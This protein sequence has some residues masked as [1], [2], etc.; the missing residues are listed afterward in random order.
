MKSLAVGGHEIW[1][2]DRGT[3]LPLVLLHGF[4][5]DHT[6][7]TEQID[8]LAGPVRVLAAR[9]ARLRPQPPRDNHGQ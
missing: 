2:V 5:L 3:G 8:A 9:S 7:W 4:P 6:M 1:Y